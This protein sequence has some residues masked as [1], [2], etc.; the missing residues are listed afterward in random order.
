MWDYLIIF[1]FAIAIVIA[2]LVLVCHNPRQC[3]RSDATNGSPVMVVLGS[4]G[5]TS[6]MFGLLK[7]LRQK[8][9]K[10]QHPVYVVSATDKDSEA[11]AR[12]F[13]QDFAERR[14]VVAKIPRAREVGQSY[15]SSVL[16]TLSALRS[17]L[18]L[19]WRHNPGVILT[20]GPGVCVPIVL[21]TYLIAV[22]L[23][24]SRAVVLYFESFTCVD[25]LSLSGKILLPFCDLFSVQWPQL[26]DRLNAR[27]K[28]IN[29]GPFAVQVN[30]PTKVLP[31]G[32]RS[33]TSHDGKSRQCVVTVG[34]TQFESLIRSVNTSE[35][36]SSMTSLG[37]TSVLIQKGR[38]KYDF[39]PINTTIPYQVVQ[40][41]QNLADDIR[42]AALVV[43][44]AGAGT[45][46]D[47]ARH[48]V[49]TVVC[50]NGLLMGNH[51]RPLAEALAARR[52]VFSV[53]AEE[54]AEKIRGLNFDD[55]FEM[56]QVDI[57]LVQKHIEV[58]LIS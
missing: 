20:N 39:K 8:T 29:L 14:S 58:Y 45:I 41:K 5:H 31:H 18:L 10:M 4:G 16:T 49:P 7:C 51:Q 28:I 22:F 40:Y 48:G 27:R 3:P 15:F 24:R 37:I 53:E 47:A 43:S 30:H 21:S 26:Q 13:E 2:R 38:S 1:Y 11:V 56:P 42:N 36:F 17:S 32:F 52:H 57:K 34:S 55:L 46:L 23:W 44:H 6:E 54:V 12:K 9:W 25:H 50:P 35:F 33:R 19:V